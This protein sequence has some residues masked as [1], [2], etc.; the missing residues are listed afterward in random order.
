MKRMQYWLCWILVTVISFFIF[1][2]RFLRTILILCRINNVL[3][4][5]WKH[6]KG[7]FLDS[8]LQRKWDYILTQWKQKRNAQLSSCDKF[9]SEEYELPWGYSLHIGFSFVI[10]YFRNKK[11]WKWNSKSFTVGLWRLNHLNCHNFVIFSIY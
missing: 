6:T 9:Y 2:L 5:Q 1:F 4:Q 11:E 8:I 3:E 7:N 10:W